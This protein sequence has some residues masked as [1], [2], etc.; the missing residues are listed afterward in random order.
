MSLTIRPATL[1]DAAE[2]AEYATR[3]FGEGLPGILK[4]DVPTVEDERAFIRSFDA[5]N[6]VLLLAVVDERIV[7]NLGFSGESLVEQAHS[8]EFGISVSTEYRGQGIGTALIEALLAWAPEHGVSRIEVRS[9]ANNPRAT[10]LYERMGFEYEGTL[11]AAVI[12]DGEPVDVL[13]MSC[14]LDPAVG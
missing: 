7:G 1:D 11:R 8:G 6:R 13:V 10:A 3:L 14:L 9:W 5:P 12:R 2:L 4:R